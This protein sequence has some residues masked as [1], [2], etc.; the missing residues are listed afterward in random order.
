MKTNILMFGI[1]LA[2]LPAA[3]GAQT[4]LGA[5]GSASAR[6]ETRGS[7][8]ETRS[9]ARGEA[10]LRA[11]AQAGLPEAPVRRTIA[12]GE[13]RGASAA[14]IDRAAMQVHTRLRIAQETLTR[15]EERR[16]PSDAEIVAGAEAM[17]AGA[18]RADLEKVRDATP[19]KRT[20]TASLSA[21][22]QLR[23]RGIDGASA[24]S[25]IAA[26]L[27]SGASDREIGAFAAGVTSA[28]QLELEGKGAGAKGALDAAAGLGATVGGLGG[29]LGAGA[30]VVG[31]VG[32]GILP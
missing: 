21:L 30:S 31:S 26:R 4:T 29:T 27:E 14:S 7:Q 17:A 23:G 32:G 6:A 15:G 2:I 10:A 20:M 9:E 28:A 25:A 8:G 1:A 19:R 13:A 3:A 12:E 16:R 5:E 22:A 18:A 11:N 24:A